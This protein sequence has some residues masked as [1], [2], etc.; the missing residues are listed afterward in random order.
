MKKHGSIR[1]TLFLRDAAKLDEMDTSGMKI[2]EDDVGNP[3]QLEA[4]M[5]GQGIVYA[6]LA[7]EIEAHAKNIVVQ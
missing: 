3:A 2:V 4:A 5:K 7:G 1:A 6:N